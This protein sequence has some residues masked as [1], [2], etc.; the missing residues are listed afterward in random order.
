VAV[1]LARSF[2]GVARPPTRNEFDIARDKQQCDEHRHRVVH[3][4]LPRAWPGTGDNAAAIPS[5]TGTSMP[6]VRTCRATR[7]ENGAAEYSAGSVSVRLAHSSNR[8]CAGLTP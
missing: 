3:T 6:D 8:R 5:A 1:V 4:A 7:R 2:D